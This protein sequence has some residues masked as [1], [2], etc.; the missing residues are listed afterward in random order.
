MQPSGNTKPHVQRVNAFKRYPI[1]PGVDVGTDYS[2]RYSH[3]TED[4]TNFLS[5]IRR[6]LNIVPK[7]FPL[8]LAL[9][10]LSLF[11]VCEFVQL[12]KKEGDEGGDYRD[13]EVDYT[14]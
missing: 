3:G 7:V 10:P 13:Y 8:L 9:F 1:C 6:N 2:V 14:L 4:E 5:Q 11:A 12:E